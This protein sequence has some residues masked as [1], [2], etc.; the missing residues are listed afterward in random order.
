MKK[1]LQDLGKNIAKFRKGAGLSQDDLAVKAL[2]GRRT[3]H[4]IETG[5]T[6]PRYTTM[7]K[8][9]NAL[10]LNVKNFFE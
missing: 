6:D 3:I 4:R 8:I 7:L 9:A 2:V 5:S 10:N 1:K